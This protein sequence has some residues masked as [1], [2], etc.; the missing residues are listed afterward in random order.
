MNAGGLDSQTLDS[1]ET[2]IAGELGLVTARSAG[3]TIDTG[4]FD[5]QHI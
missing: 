5:P 3:N 4:E 1:P 2:R